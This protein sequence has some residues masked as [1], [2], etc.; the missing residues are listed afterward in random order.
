[1]AS[2]LATL[3]T[4]AKVGAAAI[5][6]SKEEVAVATRPGAGGG[7][8]LGGGDKRCA[9]TGEPA[10]YKDPVSGLHYAT[11]TPSASCASC[12]RARAS[13]CSPTRPPTAMLRR[14][15]PPTP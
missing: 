10:K 11:S 12:I 3:V 1:M 9:I 4:A 6:E 15:P 13:G 14:R 7:D 2:Q 5:K 8:A